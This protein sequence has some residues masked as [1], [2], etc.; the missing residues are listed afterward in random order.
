MARV[1]RSAAAVPTGDDNA[2]DPVPFKSMCVPLTPLKTIPPVH[3]ARNLVDS[4]VIRTAKTCPA[5]AT[6]NPLGV[7]LQRYIVSQWNLSCANRHGLEYFGENT[8]DT[9]GK[10][11]GKGA[12]MM[13]FGVVSELGGSQSVQPRKFV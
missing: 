3:T 11:L 5:A 12:G 2:L 7:Y 1:D 9:L 10:V 8:L 6:Q 4:P 13:T